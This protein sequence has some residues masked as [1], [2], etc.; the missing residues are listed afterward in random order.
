[1]SDAITYRVMTP[2][3]AEAASALA[4]ASFDEFIGPDYTPHGIEEFRKYAQADAIRERIAGDHFVIVGDTGHT[5]AGMIEIRQNNH[6]ALLFV[7]TQ[8]H[9]Q[10][11]ARELLNNALAEAR[12]AQPDL[13]R[14][15]V[16][17]SRHGVPAYEKLGFR[18]TGPQR[19]VNG[20]AFVP[21]AM[22]LESER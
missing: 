8:F 10:G 17:S 9:R 1:M 4:I 3:E 14:V 6:V 5:L 15:T 19:S 2:S 13:E 11:I 7:R 16:N 22:R 12:V 21:M 20:I 18:Q